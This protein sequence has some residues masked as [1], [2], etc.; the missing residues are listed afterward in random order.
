MGHLG[1]IADFKENLVALKFTKTAEE[2]L[3]EYN[4]CAVGFRESEEED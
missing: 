4:G 2:F 1:I 3:W